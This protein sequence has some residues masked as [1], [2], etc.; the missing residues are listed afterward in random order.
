V[1]SKYTIKLVVLPSTHIHADILSRVQRD[2]AKATFTFFL[3][4]V[5]VRREN[6]VGNPRTEKLCAK[7]WV[8]DLFRGC[9]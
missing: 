8:V 5:G 1:V 2:N 3:V 4:C 6:M 7:C 9:Q